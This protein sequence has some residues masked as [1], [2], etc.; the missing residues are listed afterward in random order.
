LL[1]VDHSNG[2]AEKHENDLDLKEMNVSWGEQCVVSN[3]IEKKGGYL[4]QYHDRQIDGMVKIGCKQ[5]LTSTSET[6]Q[7]VWAFE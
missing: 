2:H 3:S 1:S 5:T 7:K 6:D 4:V